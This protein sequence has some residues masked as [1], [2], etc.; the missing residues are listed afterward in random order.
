MNLLF[1]VLILFFIMNPMGNVINYLTLMQGIVP[2][3]RLW[4]GFREMLIA[5]FVMLLF[6]VIGDWLFYLLGFS[7]VA[8][9]L[10]SGLI[11]LLIAIKI[12]FPPATKPKTEALPGEP[13]IFPFAVPM[14]A[15]PALLATI[16]LYSHLEPSKSMTLGAILIAWAATSLILFCSKTMEKILGPSG[17]AAAERLMA[18]ILVLLAIQRLTL[19]IQLF[20]T[21]KCCD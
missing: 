17:L 10:A 2:E 9:R 18:M 12:L 3:R 6:Y 5:L 7:E 14:I 13:F 15:G 1:L 8:L 19:G 21:G 11:L 4:V 16:M 20:V